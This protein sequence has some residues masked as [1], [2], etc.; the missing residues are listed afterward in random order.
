MAEHAIIKPHG[1][2]SELVNQTIVTGNVRTSGSVLITNAY[3][4]SLYAPVKVKIPTDTSPGAIRGSRIRIK[5]CNLL[6]PSIRAASSSSTG[7]LHGRCDVRNVPRTP[8]GAQW[9]YVRKRPTRAWH[10]HKWKNGIE[11]SLPRGLSRYGRSRCTVMDYYKNSRREFNK[12]L[13]WSSL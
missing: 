1:D 10:W 11:I 4:N 3:N 13:R 12:T 6:A 9:V 7:M 2:S 5:A 8:S